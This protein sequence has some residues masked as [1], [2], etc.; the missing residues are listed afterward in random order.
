MLL[1]VKKFRLAL[2]LA[3]LSVSLAGYSQTNEIKTAVRLADADQFDKAQTIFEGLIKQFPKNGNVFYYYGESYLKS[4]FSDTITIT[5]SEVS[6]AAAELFKK[7]NEVDPANPLNMVGLGKVAYYSGDF[8]T[9]KS[10]FDQAE[11]KFPSKANKAS[12]LSKSDQATTLSEISE[13]YLI[14]KVK[15]I[16]ISI[17]KL[18]KALELDSKNPD[19]YLNLGE[20]YMEKNDG[21]KAISNYKMAQELDPKSPLAKVNL[22]KLWVRAKNWSEAIN[23][24]KEAIQIDSTFAPA[25][26][27]LGVLY[28]RANQS[29]LSKK[30]FKKYIDLTDNIN[31]K[32]KYVNV[33]I[34]IKDFKEAAAQLEDIYK[35]DSSRNDLNRGLAYCYYETQ[36][37]DKA[38]IYIDK[39]FKKSKPEKVIPSDY[40]YL[41]RIQ[42]KKG[43]DS[44]AIESFIMAYKIDTANHD[45]LSDI[46]ASYSK[47]KKYDHAAS[48]YWQKRIKNKA[49]M[50]DFY[51]LGIVYI[52]S[53]KWGKADTTFGY[54]TENK[55]EFMGGNAFYYRGISYSQIDLNCDTTI[56]KGYMEKYIEYA[57]ID[58]VKNAKNLINAY[59]Y[60]ASFYLMNKSNKDICMSV[61]YWEKMLMLD[62]KNQKAMDLL[63]DTKGKCP[64]KK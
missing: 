49:T 60:L 52:Q 54:I 18:D 7:G 17:A 25:F 51:K 11:A 33:L 57:K 23:Y 9:A 36:E 1:S 28:S 45:I 5:L 6:A 21:S 37:Y 43:K 8:A 20:A 50:S 2:V 3:V 34:E 15:N 39:F 48:Y 35:V 47:M 27:E 55:P 53:Q 26:L 41:G 14:S 10:Y 46:A 56:A 62:P 58:S 16:D 63:K 30:F 13:T 38:L 22:G 4:Y 12:T 32:L 61:F 42:S 31:A 44:L 59:D 64:D 24:Y 40:L 19:I 29:Q